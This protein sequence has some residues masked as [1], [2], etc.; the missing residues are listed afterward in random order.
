MASIEAL[1]VNVGDLEDVSY[2][3]DKNEERDSL[4]L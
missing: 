4:M 1:G 2:T 3:N